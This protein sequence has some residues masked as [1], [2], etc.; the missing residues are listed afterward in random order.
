MKSRLCYYA[1][2]LY[3]GEISKPILSRE[4]SDCDLLQSLL[5]QKKMTYFALKFHAQRAADAFMQSH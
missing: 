1:A 5:I 3:T 2:G 4:G